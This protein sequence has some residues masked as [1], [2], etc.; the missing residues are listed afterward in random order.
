MK[1]N[2]KTLEGKLK[3]ILN[4]MKTNQ[5]LELRIEKLLNEINRLCILLAPVEEESKNAKRIYFR[6]EIDGIIMMVEKQALKE[7][8]EEIRREVERLDDEYCLSDNRQGNG[9]YE[10]IEDIKTFLNK[11]DK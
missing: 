6:Q 2:T 7:R 3:D 5:Q 9:Y 11:L 8:T 4:S 10:A 1:E